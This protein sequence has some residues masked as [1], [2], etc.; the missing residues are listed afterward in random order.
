[1]SAPQARRSRVREEFGHVD[2]DV[3]ELLQAN[4]RSGSVGCHAGISA[5]DDFG[6]DFD[7]RTAKIDHPIFLYAPFGIESRFYRTIFAKRRVCHLDDEECLGRMG[8]PVVTPRHHG[9]VCLWLGMFARRK[10]ALN[11][12]ISSIGQ[13]LNQ[14]ASQLLNREIVRGTLRTHDDDRTIEELHTFV[15]EGS[16][17]CKLLVFDPAQGSRRFRG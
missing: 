1:M 17:L 7:H 14:D 8:R 5:V 6:V 10:R 9:D 12:D 2:G 13:P 3:V 11:A 15:V 16:E 4:E